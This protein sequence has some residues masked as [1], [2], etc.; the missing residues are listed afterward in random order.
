MTTFKIFDRNS[1]EELIDWVDLS[2]SK[3]AISGEERNLL[4]SVGLDEINKGG[5]RGDICAR[6][7]ALGFGSDRIFDFYP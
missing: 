6:W 5:L 1:R 3:S 4:L 2:L 7:K